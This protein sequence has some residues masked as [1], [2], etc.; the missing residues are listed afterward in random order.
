MEMYNL[1]LEIDVKDEKKA[2]AVVGALYQ[3]RKEKRSE[4]KIKNNGEKII[5]EVKAQD[6]VAMRAVI[7]TNLRLIDSCL[8]VI[9]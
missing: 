7:N 1:S 8:K 5:M 3:K 2:E 9:S 4:V 6:S